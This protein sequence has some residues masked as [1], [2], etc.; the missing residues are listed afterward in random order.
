LIVRTIICCVLTAVLARSISAQSSA[1]AGLK[2]GREIYHAGCAGCHGA[3][4]RGAPQSTTGFEK[5]A[6]FP[7]FTRCDQTTIEDNRVWKAIIRDGGPSRGF[8]HIM[9]SFSG[10]LSSQQIDA[11]ISYLR[12]F[13]KERAW[14]RAELNVP[15]A[16]MTEKAYPE[17]EEVIRTAVNARGAPGIAAEIIHEQRF[18][19]RNQL[20]VALPV[21]FQ[22]PRPGLWYGGPGDLG[23]GVKRVM[24]ANLRSGSLVS[25][26]GGVTLPTANT[27]HGLGGGVTEFETFAAYTQLLPARSFLQ[28]QGG[29]TLPTDT[30]RVPQAGFFRT[31]LGKSFNQ[32]AG[33]GRM[34]SPMCEF[35]ADRNLVNGARTYWDVVP[36]FQVTLSKRQHIRFD[37]GLRIPATNTSGRQTQV[38]FYLLWDWLDGS[39]LE[40]WR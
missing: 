32:N 4:G 29:A 27:A 5:P 20:E 11:V 22:R 33:L 15:L 36:Q 14:P 3:D 9:A 26:F 19:A 1:A 8:S 7:D 25:L 39:L 23:F 6:T 24:F 38:I 21:E 34:W 13:C 10:V 18:G 30:K 17:G 12:G 37:A 16:L 31:A 28:L 2:S 35:V 40:G